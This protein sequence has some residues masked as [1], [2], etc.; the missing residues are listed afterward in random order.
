[1]T[2][3]D[4]VIG[5]IRELIKEVKGE[6]RLKVLTESQ[7]AVVYNAKEQKRLKEYVTKQVV[8]SIKNSGD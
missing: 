2:G 3:D 8:A 1:M 4:K 7:E 6:S 5:M